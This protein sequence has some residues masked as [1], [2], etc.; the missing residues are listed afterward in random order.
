MDNHIDPETLS[1]L[2]PGNYI[3]YW[4]FYAQRC[5]FYAFSEMLKESCLELGKPYVVT[6]PQWGVLIMLYQHDGL[7]IGSISQA[8]GVDAATM[9]G[10][11]KRLEL[12]GLVERLHDQEDRRVVKVYITEEA[13]QFVPVLAQTVLAFNRTLTQ[14]FS[15]AE[16][17]DMLAKLKRLAANVSS[18]TLATGQGLASLPE[19][20]RELDTKLLP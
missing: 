5:S 17:R 4:L 15:V 7:T 2:D 12:S 18:V 13:K 20:I 1:E 3:G 16:Q 6:P 8:R 10:I 19:D 11:V 9:T 14:G